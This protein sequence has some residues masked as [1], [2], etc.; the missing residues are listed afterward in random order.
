MVNK[1]E[2]IDRLMHAL[3][4]LVCAIKATEAGLSPTGM[5]RLVGLANIVEEEFFSKERLRGLDD[6]G[7][8]SAG[9]SDEDGKPVHCIVDGV[10]LAK[11][12]RV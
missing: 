10:R 12:Q 1:T 7:A 6:A 11:K 2:E 5:Q 8:D 3:M 9:D 4:Q